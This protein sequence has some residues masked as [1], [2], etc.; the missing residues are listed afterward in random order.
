MHLDPYLH[1]IH[2]KINS[3]QITDLNI[4]GKTIK[5][6]EDS[7][8]GSIFSWLCGINKNFLSR[9]WHGK[10]N[11]VILDLIKTK[12]FCLSKDSIKKEIKKQAHIVGDNICI[13]FIWRKT[14]TKIYKRVINGT[15]KQTTQFKEKSSKDLNS[16]FT[17][18][19]T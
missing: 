10:E 3:K 18:E 17:K 2:K 11:T 19:D 13:T 6:L 15:K 14:Q 5:L 9:T 16:H 8:I 12:N 7:F 4:E 1:T